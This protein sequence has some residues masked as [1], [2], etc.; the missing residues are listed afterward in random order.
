MTEERRLADAAAGSEGD[1]RRA[2]QNAGA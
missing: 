2:A 1:T